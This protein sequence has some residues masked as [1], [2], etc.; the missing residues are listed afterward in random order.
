METEDTQAAA[1]EPEPAPSPADSSAGTASSKEQ[2]KDKKRKAEVDQK[3]FDE[4][5]AEQL[6]AMAAKAQEEHKKIRLTGKNQAGGLQ[7]KAEV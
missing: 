4:L 3:R 7:T 6:S 2:D 5:K 1:A